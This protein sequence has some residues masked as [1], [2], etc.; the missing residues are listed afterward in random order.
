MK[1]FDDI[2]ARP[3]LFDLVKGVGAKD[4]KQLLLEAKLEGLPDDLLT[5]LDL[6]G[7]GEIFETESLLSP[8]GES[9]LGNNI[10]SENWMHYEKG[11]P[12]D[13]IVF[14]SGLGGLSAVDV[15]RGVYIQIG[16]DDYAV[17]SE[18]DSFETWYCNTLRKEYAE[19]Y[20]LC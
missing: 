14:H 7:G 17:K 8:Y 16:E 11:M 5:V 13:Y 19:R 18:Y 2:K 3:D 20:G 15:S 12:R 6:V 10:V 4:T 1:L 9:D